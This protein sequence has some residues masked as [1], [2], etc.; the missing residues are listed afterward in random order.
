MYAIRSYY[1]ENH[2]NVENDEEHCDDVE[3]DREALARRPDRRHAALIRRQLNLSRLLLAD[4]PGKDG[5]TAGEANS[6][7]DQR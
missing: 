6:N 7:D 5:G 2:L 1:D 3:F 4:Q